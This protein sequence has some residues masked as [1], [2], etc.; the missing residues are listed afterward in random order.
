M[1]AA[2]D[3]PTPLDAVEAVLRA[4]RHPFEAV[5]IGGSAGSW[6]PMTDILSRLP[7]DYPLPLIIVLHVHSEQ[8][9]HFSDH[10]SHH[11][12][13]SIAQARDKAAVRP[14]EVT[15]APPGYHLLIEWDKTFSLSVDE[16]VCFSRPSIDVLFE[17]AASVYGPGLAAILLSGASH[18]G[19][20]GMLRVRELG[21]LN[22][23]QDP[24]SSRHPMMPL[25]ALENVSPELVLTPEALAS[26]LPRLAHLPLKGQPPSSDF[27]QEADGAQP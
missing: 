18:D 23:V 25:S 24:T 7:V 22:A 13:L 26:L 17:S 4:R 21:G 9:E 19:T 5:V 27:P 16:K 10:F 6:E 15:F 20:A 2:M 8:S 3:S 11:C 12:A 14:G 1:S